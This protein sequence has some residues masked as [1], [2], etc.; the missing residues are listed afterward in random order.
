MIISKK[1][2]DMLNSDNKNKDIKQKVNKKNEKPYI[3]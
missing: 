2:L 3:I 1:K